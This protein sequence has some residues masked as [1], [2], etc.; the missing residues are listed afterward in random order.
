[1]FA[2]G[3]R[4]IVR[5]EG[6]ARAAA[7]GAMVLTLTVPDGYPLVLFSATVVPF[8][9]SFVLG[10][11]VMAARKEFNVQ[12]PNLYATPGF[13]KQADALEGFQF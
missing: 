6:P 8:L 2:E 12:Y 10:G 11:K 9:T 3:T 4:G 13:H 5:L 7:H 1:M